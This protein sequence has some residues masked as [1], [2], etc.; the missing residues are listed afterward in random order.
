M[1]LCSL[2]CTGR[3]ESII[4]LLTVGR[5]EWP[6]AMTMDTRQESG[7]KSFISKLLVQ[8]AHH[9]DTAVSSTAGAAEGRSP[10]VLMYMESWAGNSVGEEA[11]CI[12]ARAASQHSSVREGWYLSEGDRIT[13]LGGIFVAS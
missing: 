1:C 12:S 4:D 3:T 13:F 6:P 7:M 8:D 5:D 2:T 11:H 9:T 10:C